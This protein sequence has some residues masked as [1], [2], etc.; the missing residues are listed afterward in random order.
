MSDPLNNSP[1]ETTLPPNTGGGDDS[2]EGVSVFDARWCYVSVNAAAERM[3]G[4]TRSQLL[5]QSLTDLWPEIVHAPHFAA[6]QRAVREQVETLVQV[7]SPTRS[8]VWWEVRCVPLPAGRPDSGVLLVRQR[9]ISA[10]K[11]AEVLQRA[12]E[13]QARIA[14][15]ALDAVADAYITLD[16]DYRIVYANAAAARINNK[17]VETFLGR[18]LWEEWPASV[19]SAFEENFRRVMTTRSPAQFTQRYFVSGEYDVWLDVSAYPAGEADGGGIHVVYRDISDEKRALAERAESEE[20][21]RVLADSMPHI[22]WIT[23]ADGSVE[24]YNQRWFDYSGQ[25]LEETRDWGWQKVIHPD[26]IEFAN[27]RWV[28]A[29]EAGVPSE[30]EYRLRRADGAWRWHIG[31]SVPIRDEGGSITGWIGTATDIEAQRQSDTE[32]SAALEALARGLESL[33]LS[34]ERRRLATEAANVGTWDFMP[35]TGELVWDERTCALF[36]LPADAPISYDTFLAGLHPDDREPTAADVV[37]VLDKQSGAGG[38]FHR[39]FRTIGLQDGGVERWLESRGR[40]FFGADGRAERFLGT[41]LDVTGQHQMEV[42]LRQSEARFRL[43]ADAM[44]QMVWATD[45]QGNH[46]YFNRRWHDYTG[47]TV[48]ESLGFG[49]ALALHPD[50][51]ERTIERWRQAWEGG[52]D[53]EIEYRF[54]RSDGTY[55]WFV[56]RAEAVSDETGKTTLWVGTCTDIDDLKREQTAREQVSRQLQGIVASMTEGL[57]VADMSGYVVEFNPAALLKLGLTDADLDRIRQNPVYLSDYFTTFDTD[58]TALPPQEW[59]LARALRGETFTGLRVQVR[60]ADTGKGIWASVGGAGVYDSAGKQ[61]LALITIRDISAQVEAEQAQA[62]A[63]AR[64]ER[65]AE[66]LQRSMLI[67]PPP[68]R[69]PGVELATDYEAA[70][71]EAQVGGDFYDTVRLSGG[72][73]ALIVG[74]ATGKGLEA[75]AQTAQVKYAL[76]AFLREDPDPAQALLRLNRFVLEGQ[77][78]DEGENADIKCIAVALTVLDTV[79]GEGVCAC[80]GAEPP[81]IL[82]AA[83]GASEEL[84]AI[85]SLIGADDDARYQTAAFTLETGD[86]LVMTTDGIT[87]ARNPLNRR[88]FFGLDGLAGALQ[89][90]AGASDLTGA[91]RGVTRR[92]RLFAGGKFHDDVCLL[93]ARKG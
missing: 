44:P 77:R 82:R 53:Y 11:Q 26:D 92:A 76:H 83:T 10:E 37:R 35:L 9:E 71:D 24:Y 57:I 60:R 66:T 80:A 47:Q 42:S 69:F 68:G 43:Q 34:E 87:E 79:T 90:G 46:L 23:R 59:P 5:G 3:A 78:L 1:V 4:R 81:L 73:V 16:S 86:V 17:P 14:A 63:H 62:T 45:P 21:F 8:G 74:D 39:Q 33:Q 22:V 56:G 30:V 49:F 91:A 20:R 89:D 93:L 19:G 13:A 51:M 36:G 38:V 41:I 65:I 7:P 2:A 48:E 72:R 58:G 67:T 27:G 18:T 29:I 88:A 85:G 75:A 70:W 15:R 6:M 28:A 54:R 52:A 84:D 50:D 32:R 25:T 64:S 40:A 61:T 55:R 12:G 31:R